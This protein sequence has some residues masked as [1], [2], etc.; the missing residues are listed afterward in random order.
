MIPLTVMNISFGDK[1]IHPK[2]PEWGNGAVIKVDNTAV[3][4]EST[5]RITVRFS[6]AGLK[7][8]V[9]D[10]VP[11]D[12]VADEHTMPGDTRVGD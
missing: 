11:L 5:T 10:S 7:S 8:F 3:Q 1:V 2:F 6:S 12:V 9:G 4:G